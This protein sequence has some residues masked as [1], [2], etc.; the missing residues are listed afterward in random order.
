[1]WYVRTGIVMVKHDAQMSADFS[2]FIADLR[3]N[4]FLYT[5]QHLLFFDPQ[6]Q[7]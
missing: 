6:E 7:R 1:M 4:F 3:Q 5:N 2:Y